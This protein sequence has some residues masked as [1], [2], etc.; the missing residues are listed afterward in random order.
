MSLTTRT[1]LRVDLREADTRSGTRIREVMENLF[2]DK[3]PDYRLVH[4]ISG[5]G[6]Y[7]SSLQQWHNYIILHNFEGPATEKYDGTY[8]WWIS[9]KQYTEQQFN[10]YKKNKAFW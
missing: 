6:F 1:P 10:S 2:G 8:E 7:A 9:G 3:W 5:T 4:L